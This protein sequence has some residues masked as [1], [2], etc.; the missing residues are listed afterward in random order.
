VTASNGSC[1]PV[2][3]VV[4]P[5]HDEARVIGRLLD[6]LVGP[7]LEIVVVCNGCTDGT[8]EE[9]ARH[10]PDVR[11]LST[12]VPSKRDALRLGDAA[13]TVFPRF[14]VDADVEIS[15]R[16]ILALTAVLTVEGREAVAP[17]RIVPRDGVRAP[18]RW[19]YDVWEQL[20]QVRSGLFGR[21]VIGVSESGHQRLCALPPV[22]GDDLVASEVFEPYERVVV[23]GA[24]V[25]VRPPRRLRDLHHRRV[26]AVTGNTQADRLGLRRS[27]SVSSATSLTALVRARPALLPKAPIFVAVTVAA[28]IG[29]RS[30]LRRDDFD[31][32]RR[33]ESS[34]R[35]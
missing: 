13:A 26:R 11:V 27:E 7:D 8:E 25:V 5:A 34:R 14:Y 17:E 10:G 12:P 24:A 22:M 23:H 6:G 16:S 18:V 4:I 1:G 2:A 15:R 21:G 9:S 29:A 35:G 31:T 30:A 19:Y 28:R 3:S 32:W 20:P 33:D